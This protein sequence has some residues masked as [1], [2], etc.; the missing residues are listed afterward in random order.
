M[1]FGIFDH[2]DDSG[3]SPQQLFHDRL[4]LIEAYDRCGFHAYHL[5]E[6]HGTPLGMAP[7]PS[8]ML[9]AIAQRTRRLRFGPL[10]Y[11]LPLYHPIRLI[12]EICMLDQMSGGRLELGVGRGVSPIEVTFYGVDPEQGPRQFV[13]ALA[14]IRQG[15]TSDTL[16]FSG[17]FYTFKDVPMVLKPVQRPHPP[18]WYGVSKP[19]SVPGA[20]LAGANIVT[21]SPPPLARTIFDLYRSEWMRLG[22][23]ADALPLR[24]L[25]RHVVLAD[26]EAAALATAQRAYLP[27][28]RHMELLWTR[29]G[30]KLPLNLPPQIGP[31]LQAGSA[32][33][34]TAAG[35]KRLLD[36]QISATGAS[37]IVCDVAFGDISPK[38]A[39][40]TVEL[41]ASEVMP[42]FAS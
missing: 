11:L 42:A 26:T 30:M 5:A 22:R 13:E 17:D 40:R 28:L 39:M 3:V 4:T 32:F 24:G 10:V 23:P 12:E 29:H 35:F 8:L 34:G 38:E 21:L 33:A 18:L 36:E 20:V 19:E 25:A 37:Y 27:W 6:H 16:T 31:M 15:L 14:V 9:A 1:K 41:L 7:S 2:M